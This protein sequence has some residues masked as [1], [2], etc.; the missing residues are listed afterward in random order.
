MGRT[1]VTRW[2]S[3]LRGT[4][5]HTCR[6]L[7][8]GWR[9]RFPAGWTLRFWQ[10]RPHS[11]TWPAG[12][13][14]REQ[15]CRTNTAGPPSQPVVRDVTVQ[16]QGVGNKC[17]L[18]GGNCCGHV[19]MGTETGGVEDG[20]HLCSVSLTP[21]AV[22]SPALGTESAALSSGSSETNANGEKG[23]D[24]PDSAAFVP[25]ERDVTCGMLLVCD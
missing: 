25:R 4:R 8:V 15:E 20:G 3:R 5:A 18:P 11:L 10:A 6:Q 7:G 21:S 14:D 13:R 12:L 19:A 23:A 24:S 9:R 1:E 2:L 16:I 22:R 17:H